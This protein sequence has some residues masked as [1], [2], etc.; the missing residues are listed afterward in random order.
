MDI[1]ASVDRLIQGLETFRADLPRL[2]DERS[3]SDFDA[4]FAEA[5]ER[6]DQL[7]TSQAAAVVGDVEAAVDGEAQNPTKAEGP[8]RR[9][10]RALCPTQCAQM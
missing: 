8:H 6:L 10:H 3:R 5:A 9:R 2:P 4:L 1:A 7:T